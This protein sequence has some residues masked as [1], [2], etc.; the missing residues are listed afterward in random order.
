MTV[1]Q[2]LATELQ[3]DVTKLKVMIANLEFAIAHLE[4]NPDLDI[5]LVMADQLE[6]LADSV[7][8]FAQ[9]PYKTLI[10]NGFV[11]TTYGS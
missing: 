2:E 4:S 8:T 6:E 7:M 9:Y 11:K 10:R 5:T 3:E 1:N